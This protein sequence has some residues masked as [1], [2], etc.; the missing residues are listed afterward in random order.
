MEFLKGSLVSFGV[1]RRAR[2]WSRKLEIGLT[3]WV[4]GNIE[5]KA[6]ERKPLNKRDSQVSQGSL[7]DAYLQATSRCACEVDSEQ[8]EEGNGF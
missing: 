2:Q 8:L 1:R 7:I 3:E 6:S 5:A 4:R